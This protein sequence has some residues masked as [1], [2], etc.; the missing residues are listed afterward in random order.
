VKAVGEM[1]AATPARNS[2]A[3]VFFAV[4]EEARFFQP[5]AGVKVIVTGM[6]RRNSDRAARAAL[7]ENSP[8]WVITCGF[9]GGL[10]PALRIGDV[11]FDA[12]EAFPFR[13]R[14]LAAGARAAR[15]HGTNRIA[16]TAAK[17]T[18]LRRTTGADAVEMESA[19][20]R[21]LCRARS[22]PGSTVRV[23][24]DTASEDL[25]LDFNEVLTPALKLSGAKLA[26]ALAR[27]PGLVPKLMRFQKQTS[28]AARRLGQVM[29]AILSLD[30]A[31]D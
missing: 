15:F 1:Q 8:A 22:I 24:S 6:G 7:A 3:L 28:A 23:I 25:P 11:V 17:K 10:D 4:K 20:I 5:P 26:L 12:D 27:S 13:E 29:R 2:A 19:V 14:L 31:R 21:E 16:V 9:A 30:G 18:E